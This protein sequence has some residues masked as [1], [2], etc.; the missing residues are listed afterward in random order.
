MITHRSFSL[1]STSKALILLAGA[2]MPIG[3]IQA[4]AE[5]PEMELTRENVEFTSTDASLPAGSEFTIVQEFAYANSPALPEN[6]SADMRATQVTLRL[7]KGAENLTFLHAAA[8]TV[9]RPESTPEL[10]FEYNADST[11]AAGDSV[12]VPIRTSSDSLNPWSV[13]TA[14]FELTVTG[15]LPTHAWYADISIKYTGSLSLSL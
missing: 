9:S 7:R 14:I 3:C 10:V 1:A 13:A 11:L 8:L 4:T 2:T 6:I 5:V 12:S 15:V